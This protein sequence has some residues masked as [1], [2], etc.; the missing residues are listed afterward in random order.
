[1]KIRRFGAAGQADA[2]AKQ[3]TSDSTQAGNRVAV[4]GASPKPK[5]VDA[6]ETCLP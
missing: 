4:Y 6:V 3:Q 1:V 2:F 5:T